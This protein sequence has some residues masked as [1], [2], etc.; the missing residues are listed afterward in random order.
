MLVCD[1]CGAGINE[2]AKFCPQ[3]GDPV[4][5]AD[6]VTIPVTESQMANVEISFGQ[7]SSPNFVK[8]VEICKNIPTYSVTGEG[9][10]TQHKITLPI[11]EVDLIINLFE[12]VGSWK[13][14]QMLINGH[15]ATKKDLT[16][17]GVGCYRNRQK[18]YRPEQ[19]CFG[20]K[21][22]EANIWG[23]KKL[24][25]PINEWGGGW[26]DYGEFDKSGVWHFDKNRIKHELEIALKENELCPVLSRKRVL[27]TLDRLPDSI[28]P[29]RDNNW[30]YRISYEE[31]N[32]DYKEVAVGVKPVIKKINRYVVGGFKPSWEVETA[33]NFSS[34]DHVIKVNPQPVDE[35]PRQK[36]P[37]KAKRKSGS[38]S[39]IWWIVGVIVI[40]YLLFK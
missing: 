21:E 17:Y 28:N 11:T 5:E 37:P 14:S 30:K 8:A 2:G 24:N 38:L 23:C 29:K 32:G 34:N 13:T 33:D 6:R 1:K 27:E 7:S 40:L 26:L 35:E 25:M 36:R 20:E 3:C 19:F 22:Y 31:V 39:A 9:K 4:T 10:Q 16:Y 12:L 15:A 18:A